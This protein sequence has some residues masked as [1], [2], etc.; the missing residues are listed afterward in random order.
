MGILSQKIADILGRG[1]GLSGMALAL[2]C[3]LLLMFGVPALECLLRGER[4]APLWLRACASFAMAS[5]IVLWVSSVIA[6]RLV[7]KG[8]PI[9]FYNPPTVLVTV[10][11][12]RLVRHPIYLALILVLCG[13]A[14]FDLSLLLLMVS[15]GVW[16]LFVLKIMPAEEKELRKQF[17]Q[18]YNDYIATTPDP[19]YLF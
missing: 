15:G 19:L 12:Y 7:G 8:T 2:G 6:L 3:V 10:G 4:N 11:P 14:A 5:G 9:P 18:A 13:K 1:H 16:V 17:G